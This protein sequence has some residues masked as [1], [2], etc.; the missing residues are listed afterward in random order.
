VAISEVAA[1]EGVR[2]SLAW[3]E[4]PHEAQAAPDAFS[5]LPRTPML[6]SCCAQKCL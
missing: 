1:T 4:A 5:N 6:L 2:Q 3:C